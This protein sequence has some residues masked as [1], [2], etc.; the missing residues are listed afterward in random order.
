VPGEGCERFCVAQTRGGWRITLL[1]GR[2]MTGASKAQDNEKISI[3][4]DRP[5]RVP[6]TTSN[7]RDAV[8]SGAPFYPDV[9][10]AVTTICGAA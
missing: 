6:S 2:N 4:A 7:G 10:H 5:R 1:A 3:C 9:S 8:A